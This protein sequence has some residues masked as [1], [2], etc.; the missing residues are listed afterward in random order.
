MGRQHNVFVVRHAKSDWTVGTPD[1][2]RPL[3]KRGRTDAPAVGRWLTSL[4]VP[5][6]HAA[7]SPAIRTRQTWDRLSE[8]A[9]LH[10]VP[11]FPSELY[12][13]GVK[14]L[15]EVVWGAP[16]DVRSVLVVAH[17]PGV[18]EFVEWACGGRGEDSALARMRKKFATAAGAWLV[19]DGEFADLRPGAAVLR[20]FKVCRG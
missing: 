5:I 10:L 1:I 12:L 20:E 15:A 14:E 3:N 18:Q 4:A 19:L 8:A 13:G 17:M 2:K 9:G 11:D 6:E 16:S 7:V